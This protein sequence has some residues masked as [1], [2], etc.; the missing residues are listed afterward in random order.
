M[1]LDLYSAALHASE[2]L[3][4]V[5]LQQTINQLA[6]IHTNLRWEFEVSNRNFTVDLVRI[7]VVEGR[8]TGQHLEKQDAERPPIN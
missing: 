7:L 2:A 1:L 5:V 3:R 8:V 4:D 6:A